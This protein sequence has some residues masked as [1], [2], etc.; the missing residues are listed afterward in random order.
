MKMADFLAALL[1][2]DAWIFSETANSLSG[3]EF[4]ARPVPGANHPAW[5]L[6]HLIASER[7]MLV[8]AGAT[9]PDLP[10]G[11]AETFTPDTAAVDDPARFPDKQT[12]LDLF[13]QTRAA[14]A[15]FARGLSDDDL[16]KPTGEQWAPTVADLLA[17][18]AGHADMHVGQLQVLRRKLGK[19]I[20]F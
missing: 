8:K 14:S 18:Q 6:G 3:E 2:R 19:P 5:Q 20:M 12:L 4:F 7:K 15:A 17:V 13:R 9:M 1:E 16:E 11:F 10:P